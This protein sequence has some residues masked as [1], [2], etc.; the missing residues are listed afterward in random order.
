MFTPHI[1]LL[2]HVAVCVRRLAVLH[3]S[4][5]YPSCCHSYLFYVFYQ[6]VMDRQ[7][8]ARAASEQER[9]RR[10]MLEGVIEAPDDYRAVVHGELHHREKPKKKKR[11]K[12]KRSV[13]IGVTVLCSQY[14]CKSIET[15]CALLRHN[16]INFTVNI[17]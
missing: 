4:T 6:S 14:F 3:V 12:G 11:K 7:E 1:H 8:D 13:S 5:Q 2:H 17:Y 15:R 10:L 16:T 9:I